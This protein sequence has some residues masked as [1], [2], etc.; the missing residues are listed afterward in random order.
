MFRRNNS[1]GFFLGRLG[2]DYL[3]Q[4]LITYIRIMSQ[5]H[6]LAGI[7]DTILITIRNNEFAI[8]E[9]VIDIMSCHGIQS[10]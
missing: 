3:I 10:C 7:Y 1:K 8:P 2:I 5:T 9:L 4:P 6:N